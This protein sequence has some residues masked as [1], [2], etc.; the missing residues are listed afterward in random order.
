MYVP[1][2]L[3]ERKGARKPVFKVLLDKDVRFEQR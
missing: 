3:P 2:T 1:D